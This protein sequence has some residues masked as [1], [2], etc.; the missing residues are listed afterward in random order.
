MV[1]SSRSFRAV[2][3]SALL[4]STPLYVTAQ[5][6]LAE[7]YRSG[8]MRLQSEIV[9][10][11]ENLPEG[12]YFEG[13][14]QA[15]S[16]AVDDQGTI[17]CAD[18][19]ANHIKT[20]DSSGMFLGI[21]GREGAGPAE[22]NLP[23]F[24]T[25]SQNRLVVWDMGN[26][27]FS[28]LSMDGEQLQTRLLNRGEEGWPW[29]LQ[30]LPNGD[31]LMESQKRGFGPNED[32]QIRE[33][34]LYS[35]DLE[36]KRTVYSREV[37]ERKWIDDPPMNILV[38]FAPRV[39]WGLTPDGKVVVGFGGE[40]RIEIYDPEGGMI[41]SFEHESD[42]V[43]VTA[44]D[45][46]DWFAGITMSTSEGDVAFGAPD[47][48][49]KNTEF[50]RFRP[51]FDRII[52]DSDGNI[53]V[54]VYREDAGEEDSYYDAFSPDGAFLGAV[55]LLGGIDFPP[56][57]ASVIDGCFWDGETGDMGQICIVRY[58]LSK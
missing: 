48:I 39:H 45:R 8:E 28:I 58:R 2:A 55:K 22:F 32:V 5:S 43:R 10:T 27:R 12:I 11:D 56:S 38:P 42:P 24:L 17:Y 49:V 21:I 26:V 15:W 3:V 51:V 30:V 13:F 6:S 40:Y 33:I 31:I 44:R 50:P 47:Y 7:L 41:D 36:Y 52:V 9:I 29:R 46:E 18:L 19:N 34:R 37:H 35:P 20:F 16:I 4:L 53:L 14:E 25:I 23:Y 54:H 57:G 1:I